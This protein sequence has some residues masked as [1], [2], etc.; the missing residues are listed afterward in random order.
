MKLDICKDLTFEDFGHVYMLN[1]T[2][3]PS[4]TQIMKP[5]TNE[6]YGA[7][8]E[9]VLRAAADRGTTVHEGFELYLEYGAEDLPLDYKGYLDGFKKF[10][11]DYKVKAIATEQRF[12]HKIFRYAGTADLIAE[13]K[14]E[15]ILIDYKTT[16]QL[17]KKLTTVQLA[18]YKNALKSNGINIDGAAILHVDKDGGYKFIRHDDVHAGWDVFL[19]LLKIYQYGREAA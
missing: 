16:A 6:V 18:A 3:L 11:A 7:I 14:G 12:Y 17:Q 8:D 10:L 1:G 15:T 4:T 19:A 9:N 2:R 5:L 13:I